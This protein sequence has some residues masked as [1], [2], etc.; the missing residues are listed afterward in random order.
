MKSVDNLARESQSS[1]VKYSAENLYKKENK[2]RELHIQE[3]KPPLTDKKT[4]DFL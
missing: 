2:E 1:N 4:N 3:Q